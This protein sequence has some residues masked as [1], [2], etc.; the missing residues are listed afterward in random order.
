MNTN[1]Y[2]FQCEYASYRFPQK[3]STITDEDGKAMTALMGPRK[4][5]QNILHFY[6]S[7]H[8]VATPGATD[9]GNELARLARLEPVE[10]LTRYEAY[11]ING[12]DN[13]GFENGLVLS[14][15]LAE[16]HEAADQPV[17]ALVV[18]PTA[19][20]V[21]ALSRASLPTGC[22]VTIWTSGDEVAKIYRLEEKLQKF[23]ISSLEE[24][25]REQS[26]QNPHEVH[27][28]Y[29]L[30]FV[31]DN[32]RKQVEDTLRKMYSSQF[33][34]GARL[35]L[36]I[37]TH[38]FTKG[39][40][41]YLCKDLPLEHVLVIEHDATASQ[42]SV[43]AVLT[44]GRESDTISLQRADLSPRKAHL[45]TSA[46]LPIS[47]EDLRCST[48][49]LHQLYD[50]L[51]RVSILPNPRKELP[52]YA[53]SHWVKLVY[54]TESR[55]NNKFRVVA[56]YKGVGTKEQQRK[57]LSGQGVYLN[58]KRYTSEDMKKEKEI[59]PYL[60]ELIWSDDVCEMIKSDLDA[61]MNPNELDF[62]T[63]WYLDREGL[64]KVDGYHDYACE[65]RF[66]AL[67]ANPQLALYSWS[68][69]NSEVSL[70]DALAEY[71]TNQNLSSREQSTF[72][73]QL[74][75][76]ADRAWQEIKWDRTPVQKL[77]AERE[78]KQEPRG[79][80]REQSVLRAIEEPC[81]VR[82]EK[83]L[84]EQQDPMLNAIITLK[85]HLGLSSS[86]LGALTLGDIIESVQ[87][88][89]FKAVRITKQLP[90]SGTIPES[91]V[92]VS[93]KR[94]IPIPKAAT[95]AVMD[96]L[97]EAKK[98]AVA[99]EVK[100]PN[101][102]PLFHMPNSPRT[103]LTKNK[104]NKM[105]RQAKEALKI[106]ELTHLIPNGNA[107]V[108]EDLNKYDGDIFRA[109]YDIRVRNVSLFKDDA[110]YLYGTALKSV[111]CNHYRDYLHPCTQ[112]S[113]HQIQNRCA[114][115]QAT[116]TAEVD[117]IPREIKLARG[118][119]KSVNVNTS[120]LRTETTI[121]LDIPSDTNLDLLSVSVKCRYGMDVTATLVPNTDNNKRRTTK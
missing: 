63:L 30:F 55:P 43:K 7:A 42:R 113:L 108:E 68:P 4:I 94:V 53:V 112:L 79:Q 67:A 119:K 41:A 10:F 62:G 47:L 107:L 13:S 22:K 45:V 49:T 14:A 56:N 99:E 69:N 51:N 102:L 80:M 19:T 39:I 27:A 17:S 54:R 87:H 75:L 52:R 89:D 74:R 61:N 37:P 100:D 91:F 104:I 76:I 59:E 6:L 24:L 70:Q 81:L 121:T 36:I 92:S 31:T 101:L 64:K 96:Y 117:P 93:K 16:L 1:M 20:F 73:S 26:R 38:Y 57:N 71:A 34:T 44:F 116:D 85:L 111:S 97:R 103:P 11:C 82:L 120:N 2:P 40:R 28:L 9:S 21:D 60:E 33:E 83:Y 115:L 109:F 15:F 77:L 5:K 90:A 48:K 8:S 46:N 25:S 95:P 78:A 66:L 98:L 12:E 72:L 3:P 29:T 88:M 86:V 35:H 84:E 105:V 65:Q 106:E 32:L 114:Q 118:L 18:N 23:E 110:H 50:D 58:D